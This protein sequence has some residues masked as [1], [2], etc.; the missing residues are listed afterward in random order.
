MLIPE[1]AAHQGSAERASP[2]RVCAN[3]GRHSWGCGCCRVWD[4]CAT[5]NC[6]WHDID[7]DFSHIQ[8]QDVE[9]GIIQDVE[10][11]DRRHA[12]LGGLEEEDIL[13]QSPD[14]PEP[15]FSSTQGRDNGPWEDKRRRLQAAECRQD[16][17]IEACVKEQERSCVKVL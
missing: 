7:A 10:R 6:Y 9:E 14:E 5:C 12:E 13:S 4:H 15:S 16:D 8:E 2:V 1:G 3:P 11:I 17:D